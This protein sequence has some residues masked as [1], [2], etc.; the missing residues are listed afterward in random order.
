M[1][2]SNMLQEAAEQIE[3]MERKLAEQAETIEKQA[4]IIERQAAIVAEQDHIIELYGKLVDRIDDYRAKRKEE[5][6]PFP[7]NAPAP[8]EREPETT[9]SPGRRFTDADVLQWYLRA[10]LGWTNQEIATEWDTTAKTVKARLEKYTP[11]E[12]VS[13][14]ETKKPESDELICRYCGKPVDE[15]GHGDVCARC[16]QERT[17]QVGDDGAWACAVV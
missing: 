3:A 13:E 8:V 15:I 16:V 11:P 4:G 7:P 12:S 10:Q 6:F 1:E 17:R 9:R 2:L 14:P 5:P